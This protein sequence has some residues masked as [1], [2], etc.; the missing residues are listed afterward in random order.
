[1]RELGMGLEGM[2]E[3]FRNWPNPG[4]FRAGIPDRLWWVA[5]GDRSEVQPARGYTCSQ[6]AAD[7]TSFQSRL[8][9][10]VTE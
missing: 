4:A 9:A 6:K 8:G 3:I 1:M 2:G 10:P 5:G 7:Q